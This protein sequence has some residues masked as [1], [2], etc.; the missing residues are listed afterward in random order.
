MRWLLWMTL[1]FALG[2][3][4]GMDAA[5]CRTAD[6][7]AIGYED[8]A[9][10]RSPQ[11]FGTR[12]RACADHDV[13][14]DFDAYV[15]GRAEGLVHFCHPRNGYRL[16]TQGYRYAG[17][18]PAEF[19][20]AFL[21]AH[22]DGYGLY[23]RDAALKSLRKR[24]HGSRER[25]KKI[26]YL[27]TEKTA[28]LVSSEVEVSERAAIAVELKQL[29][30]EKVGLEARIDQLEYEYAVAEHDYQSYHDRIA[31]RPRNR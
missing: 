21:A 28:L 14:A 16:G 24:L 11:Y 10:G 18:C 25:A 22:A 17:V 9:L 23:E 8:G 5:E 1:L 31:A 19:E 26:E 4:A 20:D 15:A 7:R 29:T 6:W 2:G 27:L 3:C 30:E 13:V 12:R